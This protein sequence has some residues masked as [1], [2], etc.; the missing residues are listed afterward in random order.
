VRILMVMPMPWDRQ[1]GGARIHVELAEEMQAVG[2]TVERFTTEEAFGGAPTGRRLRSAMLAF[3]ARAASHLRRHPGRWDVVD[4]MEGDLPFGKSRLRHEGLLVCRS[5]GARAAYRDF[6]LSARRRWPDEGYG[7]RSLRPLREWE[8]RR[9]VELADRAA[10]AADLVL[11]P[12]RD[13]ERL[14][15]ARLGLDGRIAR[16][17]F[18]LSD[19]RLAAFAAAGRPPAERH[20]AQRLSSWASGR[21]A[22]AHATCR[23]SCACCARR[24]PASRCSCSVSGSLPEHVLADLGGLAGVEVLDRFTSEDLPQL[25]ATAT[26]GVF[27]SYLEGFGFAVLE[28]LASGMP[29]VAYDA[30][31]A[32]EMLRDVSW[33]GLT[34]PGDLDAFV[35]AV[36]GVLDAPAERYARMSSEAQAVAAGFR[37]REIARSRRSSCTNRA[38]TRCRRRA[39]LAP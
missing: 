21:R 23:R 33:P 32:R 6:T 19:A 15:A 9:L 17:P 10:R 22:R 30:P 1:L 11:V 20:A 25:L 27:P 14:L 12:N 3:S 7:R 24:G 4:A 31:G 5:L 35:E 37:W 34:P 2:H 38:S 36:L 29:V 26:V 28:K 39:A 16:L 18:G 8:A 13:E